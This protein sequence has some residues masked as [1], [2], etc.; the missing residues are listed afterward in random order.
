MSKPK[1][2]NTPPTQE[3]VRGLIVSKG[4]QLL[5]K[6]VGSDHKLTLKCAKGHTFYQRY[7][8]VLYQGR[9]CNKCKGFTSQGSL[10][11][12][13]QTLFPTLKIHSNY[14]GF[15]WLRTPK[16]GQQ[17]IDLWI[18]ALK[19]AIEY[20]GE[21]HF[22]AKSK[23]GG[24]EGLKQTKARDRMKNRK[25]KEHKDEVK[26]FIRIKYTEPLTLEHVTKRLRKQGVK[27]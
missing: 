2:P 15:K 21:Q 14:K 11:N 10:F 7:R 3:E 26:V 6:Y 5:S 1:H 25:L 18:P 24:E 12:L 22:R 23:F 17:E 16:N 27:V 20:D 4:G 8:S 19:L 13:L 9:W